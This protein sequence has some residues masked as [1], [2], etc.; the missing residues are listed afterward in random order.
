MSALRRIYYAAKALIESRAVESQIGQYSEHVALKE[1]FAAE[2]EEGRYQPTCC[3][4]C[5]N[6]QGYQ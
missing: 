3:P 6:H 5:G 2:K 4:W 1:A